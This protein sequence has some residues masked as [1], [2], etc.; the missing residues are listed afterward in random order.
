[1]R[2]VF[3]DKREDKINAVDDVA[4]IEKDDEKERFVC[5]HHYYQWPTFRDYAR[6]DLVE[7]LEG[8]NHGS[9]T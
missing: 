3:K 1:M 7:T 8:F 9:N 4:N 5:N 2:A 6:Y